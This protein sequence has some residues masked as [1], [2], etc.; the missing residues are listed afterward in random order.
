MIKMAIFDLD[1]TLVDSLTDLAISVNYGLKKAGLPERRVENY[2]MY[3]G[4]GRDMLIK[5]AMGDYAQN[6]Q[7]FEQVKN[8]YDAHYSVHLNDNTRSYPGCGDLLEKLS[9]DGVMTAV[10]SN[11]PHEF[12]AKILKKLYPKH[13]FDE[14][15]GQKPEF[16]TKPQPDALCAIINI[17]GVRPEECIYIGDSDVDVFTAENARMKMAGV[18][19]GFRGR[20]E[21]IDAGAPFVADSA[22][23]LYEYIRNFNE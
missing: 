9:Q 22:E 15:W 13:K 3:V 5:R 12:V 16:R 4:S 10:L 2:K 6:K 7:L 21:L 19:W 23:Q 8:D 1:G 20:Q 17:H 11:K 18:S 14:A